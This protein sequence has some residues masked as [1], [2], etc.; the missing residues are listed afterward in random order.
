[1]N[2]QPKLL[3][4]VR[5]KIHLKHYSIRT[6]EGYISWIKRYIYFHNKRHPK[7]MGQKEI[8]AFLTDLAVKGKVSA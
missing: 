5:Q 7:D 3:D 2:R 8:E 4:L 6:D 1:M